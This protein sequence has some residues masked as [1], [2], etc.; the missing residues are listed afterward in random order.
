[1]KLKEKGSLALSEFGRTIK[2]APQKRSN[3]RILNPRG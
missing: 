1:M 3:T 2:K